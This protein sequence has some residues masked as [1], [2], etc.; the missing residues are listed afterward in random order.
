M[1]WSW[2]FLWCVVCVERSDLGYMVIVLVHIDTCHRMEDLSLKLTVCV[3][4]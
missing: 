2:I 1:V 4:S 3:V